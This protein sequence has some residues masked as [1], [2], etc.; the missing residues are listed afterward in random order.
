MLGYGLVNL[1]FYLAGV[2]LILLGHRLSAK[3]RARRDST[4]AVSLDPVS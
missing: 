1:V 3:R 4:R 2:G